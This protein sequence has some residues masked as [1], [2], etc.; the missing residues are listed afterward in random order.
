MGGRA[1]ARA[2][3]RME[4]GGMRMGRERR[5]VVKSLCGLDSFVVV[6]GGEEGKEKQG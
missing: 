4:G 1:G 5:R 3:T 6:L 2:G